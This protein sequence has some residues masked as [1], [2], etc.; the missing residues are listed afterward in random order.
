VVPR[1]GILL[2]KWRS[3]FAQISDGKMNVQSARALNTRYIMCHFHSPMLT[4]ILVFKSPYHIHITHF[5]NDN[6]EKPE[7]IRHHEYCNPLEELNNSLICKYALVISMSHLWS[8]KTHILCYCSI[9]TVDD[10]LD[11]L[12]VIIKWTFHFELTRQTSLPVETHFL[13]MCTNCGLVYPFL[14]WQPSSEFG[15]WKTL[16]CL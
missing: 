6:S 14:P 16:S 3:S 12:S 15:K 2:G 9:E 7:H 8:L 10:R 13:Q 11:H 4:V 1:G 5:K